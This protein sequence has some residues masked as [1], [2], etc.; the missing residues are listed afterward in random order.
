MSKQSIYKATYGVL[1]E[2]DRSQVARD[3]M[4]ARD[5][6]NYDG[7]ESNSPDLDE[8]AIFAQASKLA[9]EQAEH[10]A[11]LEGFANIDDYAASP[12]HYNFKQIIDSDGRTYSPGEQ[13]IEDLIGDYEG[14]IRRGEV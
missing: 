13:L 10:D 8:N 7:M 2:I 5:Q 1:S 4:F 6:A 14:M 9:M 11:Q 3:R 12:R